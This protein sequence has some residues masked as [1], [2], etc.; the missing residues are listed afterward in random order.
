M[1]SKIEIAGEIFDMCVEEARERLKKCVLTLM[2]TRS[3]K[4]KE[5]KTGIEAGV[6]LPCPF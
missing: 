3:K 2:E 6:L 1:C 5:I 4:E